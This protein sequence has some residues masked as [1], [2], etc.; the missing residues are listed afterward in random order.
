MPRV[1]AA[2]DQRSS[3]GVSNTSSGVAGTLSQEGIDVEIVDLRTLVPTD[4][5]SIVKSVKKTGRLL[6]AHEATKRGGAAGE[7][8]FRVME[9]APDVVAAMKT[10]IKRLGAKNVALHEAR[11]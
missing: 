7:I 1:F 10:P 3:N 9:A 8:A 2:L 5:E 4:V 11:N 6:I